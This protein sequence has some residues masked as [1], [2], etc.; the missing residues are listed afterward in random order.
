MALTIGELVGYI[1]AD[2]SDFQR[3]L[4]RSQLRMEGFRV[5]VNGRL[6]DVRG[7]F[8]RESQIMGRALADGFSDA[9]RAGTRIVTVYNSVADAQSRTLR[10]RMQQIQAASRRMGRELSDAFGRARSFLGNLDLGRLRSFVGALGGV[11]ASGG[12]IA[13]T[14]G[15]AV[16]LAAAL[17]ATLAN[18]APA[19]GVVATG[20]LAVVAAAGALKIGMLG[21]G[22]AVGAAF[23]AGS[24]A[25][26]EEALKGL[27]PNARAFVTEL[28][29]MKGAFD[30]LKTSVQ[31]RLFRELDTTFAR[32]AKATMPILRRSL[33]DSAGALNLMGR[34]VLNTATGLA[35]SGALGQALRSATAGLKNLIPLP[36]TL[37]QGLVQIGAAAGPSFERLTAAGGSA[38]D[39]LSQKMT[40]AFESG[41]IQRAIERAID[42]IGDLFEVIGNL[43]QAIGSLFSAAEQSGAGFLGTLKEITGAMADAF[44]SPEVQAGLRAIFQ[45][46]G[47][48]ASTVAPLLIQ[49]LKAIAPV[50]EALGPPL[51]RLIEALGEALSPII[52]ALGPVLEATAQAVGALVDAVSPLLPVLGELIAGILPAVTPLLDALKVVFE[53]LAPIVEQV[54]TI[55]RDTLAPIIE[56]LVPIIEPLAEVLANQLVLWL[57]VLGDLLVELGPSLVVLGEALGELLVALTPLIEAWG[58]LST[59]LLE[60][61]MPLLKPLI[62]LI[63][64]IAKILA[65]DLARTITDVVVPAVDAIAALLRGD[66]QGALDSAKQAARGFVDNLVRRFTELPQKAAQALAV[67]A[68]RLRA[69]VDEAGVQML[70][71][72]A[73]KRDEFVRRVRQLPG[74]AAAA[75]GN[76]GA[77]LFSAGARL[78]QGFIAGI[79][80]KF[81][82]VRSKLGELTGALTSWKGPEDVDKKLLTPAGRFLIEGFQRGIDAQIPALRGQL[83]HLTRDL[84]GMGGMDLAMGGMPGGMRFAQ[85]GQARTETITVRSVLDVTGGDE[86]LVRVVQ[87]WVR[88]DGGDV[89]LS[90]GQGRR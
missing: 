18:I 31:D 35:Q 50:F 79:V 83:Q 65:D 27:S 88:D 5:D 72:F 73:R 80:S 64:K 10:S 77:R 87:K 55:L 30:S 34:Q 26:L 19:A 45:T 1:R 71:A 25:E 74:Q 32:T 84:P 57:G 56:G 21:V 37:V 60:S 86:D 3:N 75:L 42:L 11:A 46:M 41:A 43:G 48:V 59:E 82:A 54:A 22:D 51:Q 89:Q 36:A 12:R 52:K 8:V 58:T 38:L 15:A 9:E 78:I 68:V 63:G 24:A 53:A 6:R 85:A 29:S 4:A 49:A 17:A 70:T 76:L 39:R 69:R 23:E 7:R 44:A 28:H 33:I 61:L 90:L 66:F 62:E 2:G 40:K 13:A 20:T 16:P 81:G 47:T 67:L 14:F